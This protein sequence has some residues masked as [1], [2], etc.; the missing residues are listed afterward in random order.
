[1]NTLTY[2]PL[3]SMIGIIIAGAAVFSHLFLSKT[4]ALEAA[5]AK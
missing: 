4:P 1:M 3:R 2:I 5:G